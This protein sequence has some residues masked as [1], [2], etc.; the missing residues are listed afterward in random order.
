VG[1]SSRPSH[2]VAA[3][4]RT[5]PRRLQAQRRRQELALPALPLRASTSSATAAAGSGAGRPPALPGPAP[6]HVCLPAA[7]AAA[8]DRG[9]PPQRVS[10]GTR[11]GIAWGL[12]RSDPDAGGCRF[13]PR[14]W[15]R[16]ARSYCLG[17]VAVRLDQW[18]G[19]AVWW[20]PM[21]GAVNQGK[22]AALARC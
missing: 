5:Q 4:L 7:A 3:P 21:L 16:A 1:H 12:A 18:L 13:L 8:G 14:G 19:S 6:L 20:V 2:S 15:G 9:R 11:L 22:L 17:V 10:H